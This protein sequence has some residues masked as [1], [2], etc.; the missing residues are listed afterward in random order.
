[1]LIERSNQPW[2]RMMA[3]SSTEA[4][5][6]SLI[7]TTTQPSGDGVHFPSGAPTI[8]AGTFAR[9]PSMVT[10]QNIGC[11]FFGTTDDDQTF[12]ARLTGWKQTPGLDSSLASLWVPVTLF[13]VTCTLST[14]IG[15]AASDVVN[16]NRFVDTITLT[17]AYGTTVPGDP[18]TLA[19]VSPG[20]NLMAHLVCPIKG[21]GAFQF[22]FDRNSSAAACNGLFY[23]W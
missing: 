14:M 12:K 15:I 6:P 21:F 19:V 5:F 16:T 1:M 4:S 13:E 7:P 23:Y 22:T 17:A 8:A 18:N 3:T 2:K 10:E 11:V 9:S 20:S